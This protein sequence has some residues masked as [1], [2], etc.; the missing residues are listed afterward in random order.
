MDQTIELEA[1]E[2]ADVDTSVD[3]GGRQLSAVSASGTITL[4]PSQNNAAYLAI[5]SNTMVVS[6]LSSPC[7]LHY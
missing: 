7:T 5:G 3:N 6:P 4:Q 2:P 1:T